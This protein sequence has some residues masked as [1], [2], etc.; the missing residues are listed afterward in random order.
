MSHGNGTGR[1][2]NINGLSLRI[3]FV[4]SVLLIDC[5]KSNLT[6]QV[7]PVLSL[8][9]VTVHNRTWIIFSW[10]AVSGYLDDNSE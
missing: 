8:Q 6:F 3:R 2:S 5:V 7:I 4:C 10:K 1:S 9:S